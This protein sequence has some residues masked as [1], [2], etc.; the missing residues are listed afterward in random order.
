MLCFFFR[1]VSFIGMGKV[2]NQKLD[3]ANLM[4]WS[5]SAGGNSGESTNGTNAKASN[6]VS[7]H[8]K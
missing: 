1:F 3:Y 2:L 4:N 5:I 6:G 7:S 8:E